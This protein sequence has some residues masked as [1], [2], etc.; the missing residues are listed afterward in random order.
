MTD[1]RNTQSD[2]QKPFTPDGLREEYEN[3]S[4]S[5]DELATALDE[6]NRRTPWEQDDSKPSARRIRFYVSEGV[7]DKPERRQKEA[8]YGYRHIVQYLAARWLLKDG[9]PLAKVAVE[10]RNLSNEALLALA[11]SPHPDP[12]SEVAP[13]RI[14]AARAPS[15]AHEPQAIA[16]EVAA[17][18]LALSERVGAMSRALEPLGGDAQTAAPRE[19]LRLDLADWLS[20]TVDRDRVDALTE[21]QTQ[22]VGDALVRALTNARLDRANRKK[23]S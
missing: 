22:A 11:F 10:T 8:V 7:L 15:T 23:R 9:W 6:I 2:D 20:I 21:E 12:T 17:R 16:R 3:Y 5:A 14:D 13:D 19:T 18:Q 4:G 1:D